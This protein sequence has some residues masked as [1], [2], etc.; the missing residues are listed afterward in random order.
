MELVLA[1]GMAFLIRAIV[2]KLEKW[3]WEC[4]HCHKKIDLKHSG[5]EI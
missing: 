5:D 2:I 1:I 4:P 3:P